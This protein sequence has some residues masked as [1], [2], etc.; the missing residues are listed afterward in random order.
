[1][2]QRSGTILLWALLALPASVQAQIQALPPSDLTGRA[3]VA[4]PGVSPLG[5]MD[6]YERDMPLALAGPETWTWQ[7]LPAGLLYRSYLAGTR[8]PRLGTT[9]QYQRHDG[10]QWD[11]TLGARVGVLRFGS[12]DDAW[13]EGVQLDAEGAAFPRLN[14]EEHRDVDNV[15]FRFGFPLTFRRGRWETKLAYAHYCSH[16]GDEYVL[17]HPGSLAQRLNYVRDSVVAGLGF[18]PVPSVRFYSEADWAF[19]TDGGAKPWHFQFGAEYSPI[20]TVA[21]GGAPFAAVNCRLREEVDYSG[22]FVAQAGWQWR[23][24]SGQLFRLGAHYFNGKSD[25]GQFYNA[26]EEQIGAGL[27][28]DF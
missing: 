15:D 23:G 21:L 10:W 22:S 3:V 27:W 24:R 7:L 8:E 11:S 2:T 18:R 4:A 12:L 13:P 6:Y 19:E 20:H 25:Q 26:F 28:Y 9:W 17:R 14:M 16:L 1:M 5:A